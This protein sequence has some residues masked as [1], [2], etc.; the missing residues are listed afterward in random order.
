MHSPILQRWR[1]ALQVKSFRDK[2]LISAILIGVCAFLAPPL[3]QFIQ[4]REGPT[5]NDFVLGWLPA[6]DLSYI[7]FTLLYILV[8]SGVASLIQN[9]Q[10]FLRTLQ[11]YVILT[12]LRFV[13]M[14]LIPLNP[15]LNIIELHDP[16]VQQFFYQQSVTKDLFFSGHTSVL[17][18]L[19]LAVPSYRLKIFLIGGALVVACMLLVQHAHYTVD[20]VFAPFFSWLAFALAKKIT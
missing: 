6:Q 15:P 17:V 2:F 13:T 14:L 19:A 7:T 4:A 5:L 18:L 9:P 8:L 16:L 3:F 10:L 11:A 1:L 12:V 20:V